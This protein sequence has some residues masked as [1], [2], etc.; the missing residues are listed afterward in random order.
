MHRGAAARPSGLGRRGGALRAISNVAPFGLLEGENLIVLSP[1]SPHQQLVD[2]QL[3]KSRVCYEAGGVANLLDTQIALV[4][5]GEGAAIVPSFGLAL[6]SGRDVVASR[7]V[8]PVVSMDFH[9]ITQ[10]GRTLPEGA[11][12]FVAFLKTYFAG[13]AARAGVT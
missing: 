13:W 9:Q 8:D 7:L 2:Q 11:D 12:E 4:E 3:A 10:R 5:A 1:S 6:C